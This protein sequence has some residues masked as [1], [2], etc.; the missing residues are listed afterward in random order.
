[1]LS[2][3]TIYNGRHFV[4]VLNGGRKNTKKKHMRKDRGLVY[5]SAEHDTRHLKTSVAVG[6]EV[7]LAV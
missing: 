7:S 1:M 5:E 6:C 3:V 4:P 2:S